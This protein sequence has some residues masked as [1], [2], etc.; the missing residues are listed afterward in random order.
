MILWLRRCLILVLELLGA[1]LAAA[2]VLASLLAWRLTEGPL[3]LENL[4][5]VLVAGLTELAAPYRISLQQTSI[6]WGK[7]RTSLGL[8]ASDVRI[9]T[10]EG[11]LMATIP[12]VEIDL[13]VPALLLGRPAPK[14]VRL[15]GPQLRVLRTESG[16]IRLTLAGG[17]AGSEGGESD[18]L[19]R[20]LEA[21]SDEPNAASML[22]A[23]REVEVAAAKMAVDDHQFGV[24]W[25]APRAD[26]TVTRDVDGV[27]GQ[28][29]LDIATGTQHTTISGRLVYERSRAEL[30]GRLAL[31]RF[32]PA[33]LAKWS[34]AFSELARINVPLRGQVALRW[35]NPL[36][37]TH[38]DFDLVAGKGELGVQPGEPPLAL[39]YAK[40]TGQIDRHQRRA[41]ISE[42]YL[43]FGGPKVQAS[44]TATRGENNRVLVAAQAQAQA[45]PASELQRYWLPQ[46]ARGARKWVT[47]NIVAGIVPKAEVQ[48]RLAVPL[49]NPR[50]A[51]VED[52]RGTMSLE[53]ITVHYFR[54][55]PP[56]TDARGMARFD[57]DVFRIDVDSGRVGNIRVPTATVQLLGLHDNSDR[58]DI[59]LTATGKLADQLALLDHEPLRYA[60][61]LNIRA[62]QA[63]GLATTRARFMFPLF[64]DLPIE[65]VAISAAATMTGVGLPRLV[66]GN[67]LR[68]GTLE[69]VLDGGGMKISGTGRMGGAQ[70]NFSWTESFVAD[71][72]PNSEI[73]FS[74][75]MDEAARKAFHVSWPDVLGGDVGVTGGYRKDRGQP[76]TLDTT[77]DFKQATLALP[78]F[79]WLKPVGQEGQGSVSVTIAEGQVKAIPAFNVQASGARV[80]GRVEFAAAS[81][82]QKVVLDKL[83]APG[84]DLNGD[85]GNQGEQGLQLNLKGSAVDIRGIFEDAAVATPRSAPDVEVATPTTLLPLD[86]QFDFRRALTGEG[87]QLSEAKGR[88]VR[89]P[90]GWTLLDITGRLGGGTPISVKLLPQAGGRSLSIESTDAGGLFA[91]LRLMD[92]VHGGTLNVT[93]QGQ[94]DE[95]VGAVIDLRNFRYL[96]AKTLQRIAAAAEP[97]GAE[98]LAL[99]EGIPFTRLRGKFDYAEDHIR[100]REARMSGDMLGLTLE[101][102]IDLLASRLDLA[103]TIVPLYGLNSAVSGIPI[104]GWL[105]TGGEG[106][107]VF[108]A[109]YSVKGPLR[110]PQ[111]SVNPLSIITPGF[112]REL[113]FVD[114]K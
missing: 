17:D 58:A 24:R 40:L 16:E 84:T 78:W 109:A 72:S 61:K 43:D 99:E 111:T 48:L 69:M 32:N 76:G 34:P 90:R 55:L 27:R 110:D 86:V 1:A 83:S 105:L 9:I 101:G 82:W 53:D 46:I 23:L 35:A 77:L 45:M 89:G 31:D 38:V 70:A 75:T 114:S 97:N 22:G 19:Q 112:L 113:F 39:E 74:G 102:R 50:Q 87:R 42:L 80:R 12:E 59:E 51:V 68:D 4:E 73:S 100:V 108:A 14:A 20:W 62:D 10:P 95:P 37:I 3:R 44:A 54:P 94:G 85:V 2:L 25:L 98:R 7:D 64:G 29:D 11:I 5:P 26:I 30:R 93:G 104:I 28:L 96:N 91:T 103:G 15:I 6:T 36:G 88:L 92:N 18:L 106:G 56:V 57:R 41:D 66:A 60:R 71:V 13:S 65:Q 81:R 47:K 8:R 33:E 21:L 52:M 79:G 107:G 67:D 63:Q 49:T